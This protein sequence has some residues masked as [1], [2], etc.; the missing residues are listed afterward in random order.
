MAVRA[1]RSIRILITLVLGCGLIVA[2][3]SAAQ[4]S[5]ADHGGGGQPLP[6][7]TISNPP[8][9]PLTAGGAPTRVVQ[10][11]YRH[12]A[13]DLEV[14]QHWNGQLVM[15]A[16]GYRGQG[17][18]L[19]VDPPAYGLRQT[20]VDE[21]YAW[22]ASSY[23]D[24]GYDVRS[25]VLSEHAL[26]QHVGRLLHRTPWRTY[27]VGVSMGGQVIGRSLE[28]YPRY[29]AGAL[30]MCGVLGD[31]Q[32]FDFFLDY[33]VVAQD[34]AGVHA[35]P[36]PAD[37][38]SA[39]VPR[40]E[41][42]LGIADLAPGQSPTNALGRQL[43]AI[44][45]QRSGGTRPGAAA[46]FSIWKDFLFTLAT[47]DNGG[48]LAQNPGRL[49]QNLFTRYTP[50]QPVDVN[51]TVQ[52][53]IPTDLR[54]RLSLALSQSPRIVGD[55]DVPVLTLH[56][57]GDMFVPFSMEE[58]Y[59]REVAAHHESGLLVQRAIRE[60][61]HCEYTPTEVGTAW[62]DL[63]HWVQARGPAARAAARPAGD[64]VLD[65]RVVASPTFGCRF[66]DQSAYADPTDFPTRAL[67][68]RCPSA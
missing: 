42:T 45:V 64:E 7:Y 23:T 62:S 41:A 19:T 43:Q 61:G 68:A 17:T 18:V 16:H 40:I 67:F 30:P 14:P 31:D 55:P 65:P 36:P 6:G 32:L 1:R 54:D 12:A 33:N 48:T 2:S 8:L 29:Y 47:P 28:Q 50:D 34:L 20:F 22:A 3:P 27:I 60:A 15:W 39:D 56:G 21:G 58:I 5:G 49:A 51:R 66:T 53:V 35:Y 26:A 25:G 11:V 24:N 52:R 13:F 37:Y 10:G 9:A 57:L 4:A 44:T 63:Q 46:S 59:A 38:Q